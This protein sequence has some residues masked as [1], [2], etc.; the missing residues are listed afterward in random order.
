M[1][2]DTVANIAYRSEFGF[3]NSASL[4][5]GCQDR[6]TTAGMRAKSGNFHLAYWA[7]M[8]GGVLVAALFSL[9]FLVAARYC[10]PHRHLAGFFSG[11]R[12]YGYDFSFI[13]RWYRPIPPPLK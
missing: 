5:P 13:S 6:K 4:D 9:I 1:R 10:F 2:R 11:I 12:I 7:P 8:A 3:V